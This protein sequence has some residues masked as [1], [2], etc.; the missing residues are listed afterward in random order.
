[1]EPRKRLV[2]AEIVVNR[3]ERGTLYI[4]VVLRCYLVCEGGAHTINTKKNR[5]VSDY[6][7][8]F[9]FMNRMACIA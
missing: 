3:L 2:I 6:L 5:A 7:H 9:S 1:V 4:V 8:I